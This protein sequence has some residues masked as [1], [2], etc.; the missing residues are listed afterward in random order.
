MPDPFDTT[1][2]AGLTEERCVVEK[3]NPIRRRISTRSKFVRHDH[4]R[5]GAVLRNVARALV[6]ACSWM[7]FCSAVAGDTGRDEDVTL[8]FSVVVD[9]RLPDAELPAAP[10]PKDRVRILEVLRASRVV[11][12]TTLLKDPGRNPIRDLVAALHGL[13]LQSDLATALGHVILTEDTLVDIPF[14]YALMALVQIAKPSDRNATGIILMIDE[15]APVIADRLLGQVGAKK[16][17]RDRAGRPEVDSMLRVVVDAD[18]IRGQV[19][20][21]RS[22]IRLQAQRLGR[23]DLIRAL[24]ESAVRR[25]R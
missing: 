23:E 25:S 11:C 3:T 10:S 19:H 20:T 2:K 1:P 21:V 24:D 14:D 15:V 12:G 7:A 6:L 9:P 5:K 22:S 18:A 17:L 8:R 16:G 13:D 4:Y